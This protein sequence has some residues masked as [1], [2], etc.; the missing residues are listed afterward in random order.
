MSARPNEDPRRWRSVPAGESDPDAEIGVAVRAAA[1]AQVWD[2][3]R[4]AHVRQN[5]L[6]SLANGHRAP[7]A[8]ERAHR[9]LRIWALAVGCVLL[10]AVTSALAGIAVSRLVRR[11]VAPS[12]E[13]GA[14]A[15]PAR[16]ARR[17]TSLAPGDSARPSP[18]AVSSPA[19][20]D[21]ADP[22]WAAPRPRA[23]TAPARR[24]L[25]PQQLT[26]SP[27][28]PPPQASPQVSP[29][30]M[31]EPAP[32]QATSAPASE[33]ADLADVLRLLRAKGEPAAALARLD[34]HDRRYPAGALAREAA[35]ARVEALLA[36]GRD[37][38]ALELLDRLALDGNG[39]DRRA[40]LARAELRAAAGRC[41][42]ASGDFAR[43]RG[44][45]AS[46][47][48]AG[49]ALYGDGL[50]HLGAGDL[51]GARAAFESYLRDFPNGPR[52]KD[53]ERALLRIGR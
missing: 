28:A 14:A 9:R 37:S 25:R 30:A 31:P 17:R 53:V 38:A 33:A 23:E 13:P 24:A 1:E 42:D 12:T 29:P 7:A 15:P 47:D 6:R 52:R 27:T 18:L 19:D 22:A 2:D 32:P 35:R 41:L 39:V 4:V 21:A 43:A 11:A 40:L 51:S 26:A 48:V 10:G 16:H 50:C 20:D 44:A 49:R 8:G 46:D 45:D 3:M 5:I 34:E 36:L